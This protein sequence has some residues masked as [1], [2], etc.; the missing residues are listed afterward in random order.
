LS[1]GVPPKQA[2]EAFLFGDFMPRTPVPRSWIGSQ[3]G[4]HPV[5]TVL[6]K[7]VP[8]AVI[9]VLGFSPAIGIVFGSLRW[10]VASPSWHRWHHAA[11][12]EA[13]NK[14]YSG[15]FPFHD[16]LFQP[17]EFPASLWDQLRYP[18]AS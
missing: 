13:L 3:S 18:L 14:N 4:A 1:I 9:F 10:L 15:V 6:T 11:E 5:E 8:V 16:R 12:P 17:A 7:L 2:L